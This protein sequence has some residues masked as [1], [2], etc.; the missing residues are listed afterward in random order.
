[1]L[2]SNGLTI[3]LQ[4][5]MVPVLIW[6]WGAPLFGEWIILYTIPGYLSL[7]DFGIIA[8]SN[9]KIEAH[10][11]RKRYLSA[12]RTYLSSVLVLFAMLSLV[13]FVGALI[14]A[15]FRVQFVGLFEILSESDVLTV[16]ILLFV[17]ALLMLVLNHHSALYR[18]LGKFD[19]TV[20][21][22]ALGRVVPLAGLCFAAALGANI[23]WAAL[24]MLMLRTTLFL[25]MMNSIRRHVKWIKIAWLRTSRKEV[26]NLASGA[27]GFMTLPLSNMIYLHVTTLVVAAISNPLMVA[28]FSTMRTF[29]RMI[30]QFVAIAGRSRWS[31]ISKANARGDHALIAGM[32]K[33]VLTQ[34]VLLTGVAALG[35]ILLGKIFYRFWTGGELPFDPLLFYALLINA[36]L[37]ACYYSLEVFLLATNKVKGYATVFLV[38]TFLQIVAGYGLSKIIGVA[39]FPIMGAVGALTICSVLIAKVASAAKNR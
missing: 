37:I 21:W 16:A 4:L 30:P 31:E 25:V 15:V 33:S 19:L 12:N 29:T 27:I 18:T 34:T 36:T 10:C 2:M 38:I 26:T 3:L 5:L 11:A 24:T 6:A 28:T 7:T 8:S 32:K 39:G 13:V 20:N 35:Y 9:N 23:L 22:Q 1:M 17:D 14:W